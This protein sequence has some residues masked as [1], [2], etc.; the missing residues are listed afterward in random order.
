MLCYIVRE[1][2]FP[3]GNILISPEIIT[4]CVDAQSLL[5]RHQFG[6][7]GCVDPYDIDRN[8]HAIKSGEGILSQYEVM[9]GEMTIMICVMT[10]TDRAYTDI[11]VL[12]KEKLKFLNAPEN[13]NN[14]EPEGS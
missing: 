4:L 12:D 8:H 10:E 13:G 14:R 11:F 1:P 7:F 3:L 5:R 2:L 9:V 6:D